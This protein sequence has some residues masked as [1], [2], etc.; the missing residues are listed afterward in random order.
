MDFNRMVN[1]MIRAIRLDTSFYEEVEHD[2][3]YNQDALGVVIL[4]SVIGAV[5]SFLGSIFQGRGFVSAILGLI[6]GVVLA[7]VWYYVWV[8]IAHFIGTRFF[9]GTGDRGEVQRAFGFAYAPQILGIL[10]FIPCVGGLITF[11]AWLWSIVCGFVAIK[12]SLDQDNA[13]AA[14]TVIISGVV[15]LIISAVVGMILGGLGIGVAALTGAFA[16]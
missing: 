12:Q 2:P 13:N 5:G 14:L 4:V 8:Y 11:A 16:S 6:I 1:G 7:I 10:A 15:V 3:S 9:K